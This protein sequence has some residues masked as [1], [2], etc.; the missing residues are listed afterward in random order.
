MLHSYEGLDREGGFDR[1]RMLAPLRHRDFRRLWSGMCVSLFGDGV[2]MVAM[3]W[4]VYALSDAPTAMAMVGIAM[5]IPTIAFLLLGGAISDRMDRRRVM[6]AAD[7]SRGLAVALLAVLSI[8]GAVELWHVVAIVAVYGA[9]T[10]FFGP[11]FDA[12][13]PDVLPTG[14]LAQANAL[15][16]FVRPIALRLVGPAAGGFLID[17]VGVGPAFALDAATF[18]ISAAM[19]LRMSA[20]PRAATGEAHGSMIE[21]I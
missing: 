7:V 20:R 12:I 6:L 13:V 14:Q 9:G 17:A 2:F 3:A 18:A 8:T 4:Q 21:E 15:D 19:L 5:T 10:A 1:V 16:Q 11:A